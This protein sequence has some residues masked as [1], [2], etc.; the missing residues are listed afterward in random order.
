MRSIRWLSETAAVELGPPIPVRANKKESNATA[1]VYVLRKR[2][3]RCEPMA[4]TPQVVTEKTM[5]K[6]ELELEHA[7]GCC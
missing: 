3:L 2:R 5:R 4:H 1:S 6:L 7:A